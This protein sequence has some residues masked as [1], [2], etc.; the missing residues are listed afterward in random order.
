MM[1]ESELAQ[2]RGQ[3]IGFIFQTFNLIPTL[4]TIENVMLPLEFQEENPDHS[5]KRAE[6]IIHHNPN[7]EHE[8]TALQ[9]IWL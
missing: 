5:W 8:I 3:L 9:R 2:I 6:D 1:R 4:S 7:Q